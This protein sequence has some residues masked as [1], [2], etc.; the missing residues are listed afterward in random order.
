METAK[1]KM[2]AEPF[3]IKMIEPIRLIPRKERERRMEEAHFNVFRVKPDDIYIDLLTDSGTSA[4]SDRQWAGL[5][6][7]DESYAGSRNFYHLE[8]VIKDLMGFRY[9]IPTHQGRPAE[10]ILFSALIKPGQKV[11][12][13]SH[14]DTTT[15]HI[16][17]KKGIPV[18]LPIPEALE[19]AEY[20][21]FKGNVDLAALEAFLEKESQN[22][23][24]F[25]MTITNNTGGGQPVSMENIR[26]ARQITSR[27]HIPFYF[28]AARFAENAYFIKER[29]EGYSDK[30]VKEIVREMMS[31]GDGCMMS[32]K[33]DALVNMGG[34]IAVNDEALYSQ[35]CELLI[36]MEGFITYGG[37]SG[38]DLEVMARGLEEVVE[39]DYLAYRIEQVRYLGKR[40]LDR[41]I[42][43]IQPTGGHAVYVDAKAFLP[44]IPQSQFPAQ[45][46]SVE[47]YIEAG[48]RTLELGAV[49][50]ARKVEKTGE[51]IYPPLELTRLA[52]PRRVYT[53]RHMDVVADGLIRVSRRKESIRGLKIVWEPKVLRHFLAKFARV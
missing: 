12:G 14:F 38:R 20:H 40:L 46:T 18:N 21:P 15:A 19:A 31:Y 5:M 27:Y 4:M 8:E 32:A 7:G 37:L 10:N 44:H 13:N 22:V 39:E 30:P 47:L 2:G 45:V 41:G 1:E 17:H 43:I 26:K 34:F 33:K 28:D 16:R 23:S 25:L 53:N 29:E 9:V 49:A 50:F 35:C 36:L 52:I 11:V 3:K 24:S 48:V 42:P 51:T 6:I